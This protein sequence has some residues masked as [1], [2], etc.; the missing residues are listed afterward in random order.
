MLDKKAPASPQLV[1]KQDEPKT[2]VA[3]IKPN[4]ATTPIE[5]VETPKS[6]ATPEKMETKEDLV[7][8]PNHV[9]VPVATPV[10][11]YENCIISYLV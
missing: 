2:P 8:Q 3:E 4:V 9:Q 11:T 6:V 10:E 1:K 7:A 5:K